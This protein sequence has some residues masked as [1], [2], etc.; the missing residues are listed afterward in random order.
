MSVVT[1]LRKFLAVLVRPAR[2][3]RKFRVYRLHLFA[4]A[5]AGMLASLAFLIFYYLTLGALPV[6]FDSWTSPHTSYPVAAW[7]ARLDLAQFI[8]SLIVSP[9]PTALTWWVGF[10][11]LFGSFVVA[12]IAYGLL[13]S[14]DLASS[15]VGK[16]LAY[17]FLFFLSMGLALGVADGFQP[18]VM[19]SAL[20]DV[21]F[22]FLG[23]SGWATLQALV[24]FLLYG[25][26]LSVTYRTLA[27]R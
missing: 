2:P 8:G 13:L 1:V 25:I 21:G 3:L 27:G 12:G 11:L 16:G 5:F 17:G 20:P 15:T 18:A 14:W 10:M 23:W 24:A 9:W 22:F 19:R 7:A 26:V 4:A 6:A